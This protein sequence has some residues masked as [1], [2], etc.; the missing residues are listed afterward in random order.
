[1]AEGTTPSV[2][3]DIRPSSALPSYRSISATFAI[4]PSVSVV[5]PAKNEARNLPH[6][7]S[8]LPSWLDEIVLV[9]GHSVDGTV[10]VARRL[11]PGVKIVRQQGRGKGDALLAG[12]TACQGD[13]IVTLDADGSTDGGEIIRFVGAL[14][15]GADYAKGSRFANGG[16]SDDI[17]GIRRYGNWILSALVNRMF[18]THYT[19]LCYGYNAFWSRHL[20]ALSLDCAGFEVET[21]MNIRAAQAGL[22]VQEIPSHEFTRVYGKSNLRAIRDGWRIAKVILQER[23]FGYERRQSERARS[24]VPECRRVPAAAARTVTGHLDGG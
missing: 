18:G 20:S 13:I 8:S 22:R 14:V 3:G 21:L 19:D 9:D 7:F 12:F 6:V 11:H 5:I 16:C 1:M 23:I 2:N 15:A 10:E 4:T 24:A 17:T